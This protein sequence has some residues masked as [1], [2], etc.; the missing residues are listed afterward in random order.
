M[1]NQTNMYTT[2]EKKKETS[3][4]RQISFE[5]IFWPISRTIEK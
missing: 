2:K 3:F 1:A 4:S 5:G